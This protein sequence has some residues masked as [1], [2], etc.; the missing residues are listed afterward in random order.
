MF[1]QPHKRDAQKWFNLIEN[2]VKHDLRKRYKKPLLNLEEILSFSTSE[3]VLY[4]RYSYE[5]IRNKAYA[6]IIPF[7][8]KLSIKYPNKPKM[9]ER[10]GKTLCNLTI[11]EN[12]RGIKIVLESATLYKDNN[13]TEKYLSLITFYL[14]NLLDR[15]QISLLKSEMEKYLQ[16]LR[17]YYGYYLF[18]ARFHEY[19]NNP[20]QEIME[21]YQKAIDK[22][23][24]KS[25]QREKCLETYLR[26]LIYKHRKEFPDLIDSLIKEGKSNYEKFTFPVIL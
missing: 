3:F 16:E 5:A 11:G 8:E 20:T 23:E 26:F 14:N 19:Q 7:L 17:D 25:E 12:D 6:T 2:E 9:L 4:D 22:T 13:E 24:Q 15:E 1:F 10:L 21:T 18:L